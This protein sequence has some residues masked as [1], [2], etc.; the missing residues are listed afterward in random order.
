[1]KDI[2]GC[3]EVNIDHQWSRGRPVIVELD[4]IDEDKNNIDGNKDNGSY[5][6]FCNDKK[7]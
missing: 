5:R 1:M 3:V 2:Y 4:L 6:N 7:R